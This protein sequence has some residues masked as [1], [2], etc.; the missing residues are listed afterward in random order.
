MPSTVAAAQPGMGAAPR[1]QEK[2]PPASHFNAAK[3]IG[4][5]AVTGQEAGNESGPTASAKPCAAA[6]ETSDDASSSASSASSSATKSQHYE[7]L[8]AYADKKIQATT[9]PTLVRSGSVAGSGPTAASAGAGG[10]GSSTDGGSS[11]SRS[12]RKQT[13]KEEPRNDIPGIHLTDARSCIDIPESGEASLNVGVTLQVP[14]SDELLDVLLQY[15][16][17][18]IPEQPKPVVEEPDHF[19]MM[20]LSESMDVGKGSGKNRSGAGKGGKGKGKTSKSCV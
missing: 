10:S 15:R 7:Q 18:L 5:A 9:A 11:N 17:M 6:I 16:S 4:P 1:E 8:D 12:G 3:T 19:P 13:S 2:E 14:L 20:S